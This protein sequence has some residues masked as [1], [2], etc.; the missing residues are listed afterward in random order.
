MDQYILYDEIFKYKIDV[1]SS[2][3]NIADKTTHDDCIKQNIDI[4]TTKSL[5][6][7]N[8]SSKDFIDSKNTLENNYNFIIFNEAVIPSSSDNELYITRAKEVLTDGGKI[9]C[10]CT[11]SFVDIDCFK[12]S[13]NSIYF[14]TETFDLLRSHD[15]AIIDNYR[16]RSYRYL[17]ITYDVFL[18]SCVKR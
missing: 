8:I 4:I 17:L 16:I 15:L 11:T 3:L 10:I 1:G 6:I 14:I 13:L 5:S 12:Y 2:I 7:Y 18:I 9:M